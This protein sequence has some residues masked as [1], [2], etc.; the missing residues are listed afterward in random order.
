[1]TSIVLRLRQMSQTED[2][3]TDDV[4]ELLEGVDQLSPEERE[5]LRARLIADPIPPLAGWTPDPLKLKVA[6]KKLQEEGSITRGDLR[7]HLSSIDG[8]SE[9]TS[10]D[11]GLVGRKSNDIFEVEKGSGK[12][13][14]VFTLTRQGQELAEMFDEDFSGLRPVEIALYRGLSMYGNMAAFLGILEKHRNQDDAHPD[15]MLK[16]DLVEEMATIY[17]GKASI[18]TG[19]LGTLAERLG[20]IERTRDGN[21]A[22]YKLVTPEDT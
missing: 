16:E 17:G 2:N 6:L 4:E 7:E 20:Y 5:R 1:M 14:D 3:P 12:G 11:Y 15:G 19:Y 21:R 22:R 10:P 8:I 13:Q 9:I 18:Y